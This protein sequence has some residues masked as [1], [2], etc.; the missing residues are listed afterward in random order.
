[1]LDDKAQHE[2]REKYE[3]ILIYFRGYELFGLEKL[4]E[5]IKNIDFS[6]LSPKELRTEVRRL[7]KEIGKNIERIIGT[8]KENPE[9]VVSEDPSR[10]DKLIKKLFS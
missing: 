3:E 5:K 9:F 10:Y 8:L 1:M 7:R 2:L 4:P 6:N